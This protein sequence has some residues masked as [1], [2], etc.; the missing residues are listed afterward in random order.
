MQRASKF[1]NYFPI[2]LKTIDLLEKKLKTAN[3]KISTPSWLF[4][5]FLFSQ[6]ID[7]LRESWQTIFGF[8]SVLYFTLRG[9]AD[10]GVAGR[11]V[12]ER[13]VRCN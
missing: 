11:R 8:V 5:V 3:G 4:S 10:A 1:K 2:L 7:P 13:A 9:R 6:K 12:A